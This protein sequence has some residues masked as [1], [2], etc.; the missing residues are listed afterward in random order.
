[1]TAHLTFSFPWTISAHDAITAVA[2]HFGATVSINGAAPTV[3]PYIV[4]AV[5]QTARDL[6]AMHD[7]P[8]SGQEMNPAIAFGSLLNGAAGNVPAT[9]AHAPSSAD[10]ATSTTAHAVPPAISQTSAQGLSSNV[11]IAAP[12]SAATSAAPALAN[13]VEFDSTGLAWDERIHSANKT[14]T[15]AGE[16]RAK[17]GADKSQIK[18]VELELRAKYPNGASVSTGS[19]Q[20]VAPTSEPTAA[21]FADQQAKKRA[22]VEHAHAEALR[23][24]GPQMIDDKTLG[25]LL[26]GAIK[27]V[28]LSPEQNEW[29]AVYFAKRNAAYQEFMARPNV[30]T[31]TA[32]PV[33]PA[34]VADTQKSVAGAVNVPPAVISSQVGEL[35]STGLPWDSRIHVPARVKSPSGEWLQR[36]DVPGEVKLQVQAELRAHMAGNVAEQPSIAPPGAAGNTLAVLTPPAAQVITAADASTDF[37]KLVQW[38]ATNVSLGRI[39]ATAGPDAAKSL[40]FV[41]A[42]GAGQLILAREQGAY[43]QYIVQMLQAQGAV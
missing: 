26:S 22:A 35:D 28:T 16:W 13:G 31:N 38:I 3:P 24:A 32:Q 37:V 1:M 18:A 36:F 8:S 39:S 14:K 19:A 27:Q 2:Q 4:Q 43:W 15:A 20:S 5:E 23:V 10:V 40:G 7:D 41:G 30:G 6:Q 12:G 17:K 33:A 11:Q 25:G 29:F 34:T 21:E 42:D 9:S